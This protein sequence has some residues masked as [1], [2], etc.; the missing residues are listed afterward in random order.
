[1]AKKRS[2]TR[3]KSSRNNRGWKLQIEFTGL[4]V[5]EP[6]LKQKKAIVHLLDD[7]LHACTLAARV[8]DVQGSTDACAAAA[9]LIGDG[10][11][12][13]W[14]IKRGAALSIPPK[15]PYTLEI[16]NGTRTSRPRSGSIYL[17]ADL[18]TVLSADSC[19]PNGDDVTFLLTRGKVAAA[20]S[21][22]SFSIRANGQE[23]VNGPLAL[24]LV[25]TLD[26]SGSAP[27]ELDLSPGKLWL[28]PPQSG[29]ANN[30]VQ[31]TVSN[32]PIVHMD[33]ADPP[34]FMEYN[35]LVGT[36]VDVEVKMVTDRVGRRKRRLP[37]D[38]IH[39]VPAG[40][41]QEA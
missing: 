7:P 39:C 37:D 4:M 8:R 22:H 17:F 19:V 3:S 2:S 35:R 28:G 30:T 18:G 29:D 14:S 25:Y 9:V 23:K 16:P 27:L 31:I 12:A 20:R 36:N 5:V 38:P 26:V 10:T 32:L 11:V 33:P 15:K 21:D 41:I 1:M 40:L 13:L 24:S 34:H 6:F